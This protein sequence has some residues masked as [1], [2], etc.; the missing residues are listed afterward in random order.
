MV[1]VQSRHTSVKHMEKL[2]QDWLHRQV[3]NCITCGTDTC[4]MQ[5]E[6]HVCYNCKYPIPKRK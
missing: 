4:H 6:Q 3:G 2:N 5:G 1:L